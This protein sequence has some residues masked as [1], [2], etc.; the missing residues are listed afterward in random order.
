M[1]ARCSD[2]SCGNCGRCTAEWER[3]EPDFECAV[4]G[5]IEQDAT[6]WPYCSDD[7]ARQ[8]DGESREDESNPRERDEDDGVEYGDPRDAREERDHD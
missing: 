2:A 7:C 6:H 1:S 5:N 4:C 3:D 8:T